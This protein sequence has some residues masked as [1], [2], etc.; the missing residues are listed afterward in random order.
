M[1]DRCGVG[2]GLDQSSHHMLTY[3]TVATSDENTF[4]GEF[5]VVRHSDHGIQGPQ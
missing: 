4:F 5:D 2:A 3:E 1:D